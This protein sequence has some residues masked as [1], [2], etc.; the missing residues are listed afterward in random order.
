MLSRTLA[1]IQRFRLDESGA[2]TVDWV[3]MT[4]AV[5]GLA[6]ATLYVIQNM[7]TDPAKSLGGYLGNHQIQATF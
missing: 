1:H 4:A 7:A 6:L 2:V 5:V 3:V